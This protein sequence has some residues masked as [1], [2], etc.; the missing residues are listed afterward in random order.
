[1]F[2]SLGL[3]YA[4]PLHAQTPLENTPMTRPGDI[5]HETGFVSRGD[6]VNLLLDA[7]G[8]SM[9]VTVVVS[10]KAQKKKVSGDFDLSQPAKVLDWLR[11]KLALVSFS[12]GQTLYVYDAS[13]ITNA[14][15]HMQHSSI[16]T[17]R[18]FL[19][20]AELDN[21]RYPVR[22]GS[23]DGTFYVSGPPVYVKI[24]IEAANYLD[25][26]Y[27][28]KDIN[29]QLL[30][31]IKLENSFVN[32]RRY[33]LRN[34]ETQ[35]PGVADVL[36]LALGQ[37]QAVDVIAKQDP[38]PTNADTSLGAGVPTTPFFEP[39]R[40]GYRYES[41]DSGS[42]VV[43]PYPETNSLLIRGTLGQIQKVKNLVSEIDTPRRQIELSLWIIDIKK[44]EL[45]RLG[46]QWQGEIGIGNK[47]GASFNQGSV[48]TLDGQRFLA[49]VAGLSL[50]GDASIVSRPVILTQEN[51]VAHFD[52]NNTIYT[53]LIGERAS[54]LESITYGTMIS[55]L[56]RLSTKN[57]VEMQLKIEDGSALG[58]RSAGDLPVISRT[59][60]D[61]VARVP[62]N[63]SL[64]VGGYTRDA[65]DHTRS[66]VPGLGDL[67]LIGGA[68][69]HRSSKSES[70]ARLFLIQPKLAN[71]IPE[72]SMPG[73]VDRLRREAVTPLPEDLRK[74]HGNAATNPSVLERRE[75]A[76]NIEAGNMQDKSCG[77]AC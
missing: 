28:G 60:I 49:S 57:E 73:V 23:A 14:V 76:E 62:H 56:P 46:V 16:A 58:D 33:T 64:L 13:E 61:T 8:A 18:E 52:S 38:S 59:T 31:V 37:G 15:G 24:V 25:R 19:K 12:D 72:A 55:V 40:Q 20:K 6:S 21:P 44:D 48:S 30:E 10:A 66:K 2:A 39:P 34:Q 36:Q 35:L 47:F 1:M 17:L 9:H 51:V 7:V 68:F 42:T 50:K 65:D 3:S 5:A 41:N 11:E 45:D 69:R 26:L 43:L 22:G 74:P 71:E 27:A 63:L 75:H 70:L 29:T 77:E 54:S 32:G 53:P 4:W 67:P